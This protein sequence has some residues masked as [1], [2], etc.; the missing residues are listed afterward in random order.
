MAAADKRRLMK[1]VRPPGSPPTAFLRI[2]SPGRTRTCNLVVTRAPAFP[3]GLDYLIP[4]GGLTREAPGR[5]RALPPACRRSTTS[6]S[7]LCTVS[8]AFPAPE[9]RSGFPYPREPGPR[10]LRLP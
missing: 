2:G 1:L 10:G 4:M 6:R 5:G 9:L 3:R 8:R 7:S